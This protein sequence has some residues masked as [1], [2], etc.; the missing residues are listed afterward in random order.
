MEVFR[1][2]PGQAVY[3]DTSPI[4]LAL[5]DTFIVKVRVSVAEPVLVSP[6]SWCDPEFNA[7]GL[8]GIKGM[9]FTFSIDSTLA[10]LWS[11]ANLQGSDDQGNYYTELKPGYE[12][13]GKLF[14][15]NPSMLFKFL[16]TQASDN[17]QTK[18]VVPYMDFPIHVTSANN[19]AMMQAGASQT[20]ISSNLQLNQLPD[21]FMIFVRKPMAQQVVGDS[22]SFMKIN[23]IT[24]N[25]NNQSGLLST[26][27]PE[28][29]WRM[30]SKNGVSQSWR[31][32][33]GQAYDNNANGQGV[34]GNLPTTGSLLCICP[35]YDLSLP[36]F[37]SGGCLG[38]YNLSV[39]INVTNQ[40]GVAMPVEVCIIQINSGY[41]VTQSGQSSTYTGILTREAVLAAKS[42]Q[43][44]GSSE[45]TRLVGG[46]R[47]NASIGRIAKGAMHGAKKQA[48]DE[49][50]GG[51]MGQHYS[52]GGG[53]SGL[54]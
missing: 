11:S 9:N 37:L 54:Y 43:S 3:V 4:S 34:G 52:G 38:Q 20:L 51:A 17:I 33:S 47:L 16:T 41:F 6:F 1:Y 31:E 26:A 42:T 8:V 35:A 53:L 15:N 19:N 14:N 32:F 13:G 18:N 24:V 21:K 46:G 7:Q 23:S 40:S 28:D 44:V 5:T 36:D 30:S 22:N 27:Q 12:G 29:L 39:S 2:I 50:E 48:V 45:V 25:L 10:R 49:L